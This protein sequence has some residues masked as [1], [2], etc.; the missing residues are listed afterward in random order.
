ME[1]NI[2]HHYITVGHYGL[3]RE[4]GVEFQTCPVGGGGAHNVH[5]KVERK[6]R[7]IQESMEKTN[8]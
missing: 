6:I 1:S 5:G 8:E 4:C 3:S 7:H 2:L